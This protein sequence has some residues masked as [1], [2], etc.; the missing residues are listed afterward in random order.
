[1]QSRF[2]R[3]HNLNNKKSIIFTSS[4]WPTP[5][6]DSDKAIS[7]V[8]QYR[9][10]DEN[11]LS[12]LN[13]RK[14]QIIDA[15]ADKKIESSNNY[16]ITIL[17]CFPKE[18]ELKAFSE[19]LA[20][21]EAKYQTLP[22][23]DLTLE[24]KN[25]ILGKDIKYPVATVSSEQLEIVNN[26]LLRQCDEKGIKHQNYAKFT[27]HISLTTPLSVTDVDEDMVVNRCTKEKVTSKV[28]GSNLIL[29]YK[30]ENENL[31]ELNSKEFNELAILTEPY[32][33]V[34]KEVV[35]ANP[36]QLFTPQYKP[37]KIPE[38]LN[39]TPTFTQSK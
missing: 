10:T 28:P 29:T 8:L 15:H 6:A 4:A 13:K 2:P 38:E 30:D 37:S 23:F 9:I 19:I 24:N 26:D 16:H 20:D 39:L 33:K 27:A 25:I 14:S 31:V 34:V 1:M 32:T 17:M 36:A 7:V 35:T 12:E 11:I 21:I 3:T 5:T 22:S 18:K